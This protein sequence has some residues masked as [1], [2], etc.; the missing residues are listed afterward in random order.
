[1][2]TN[3]LFPYWVKVPALTVFIL[4]FLLFIF[5]DDSMSFF[6]IQIGER[7]KDGVI[8]PEYMNFRLTIMGGLAI[9][10]LVLFA[11]SK[12]KEEDEF[13]NKIRLDSLVWATYIQYALLLIAFVT[14]YNF[15]FF[16]IMTYSMFTLLIFFIIRF[17]IYKFKLHK[18]LKNEE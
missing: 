14:I 17:Q 4:T 11:F 8:I 1:M 12:E 5:T 13:I 16:D 7:L 6:K 15:N 2:K 10:S 9:L 3:Y 18:S